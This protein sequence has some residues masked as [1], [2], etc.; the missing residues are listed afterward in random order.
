MSGSDSLISTGYTMLENVAMSGTKE[1]V[2]EITNLI[3]GIDWSN[4]ITAAHKLNQELADG[5]DLTKQYAKNMLTVEREYFGAANQAKYFFESSDYSEMKEGLGEILDAN[6]KIAASDISGLTDQ[7]G[8]LNKFMK[9]TGLSAAAV[10]KLL[11]S[12]GKKKININHLTDAVLASMTEFAS[13][14]TM[15]EDLLDTL[16]NFD[17]G[18]DENEVAGFMKQ[19]YD[20]LSENLSKGAV[21]NT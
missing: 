21:G 2:M 17:A 5:T 7:Y 6:N 15:I 3:N 11:T 1:D 10:A 18:P 8:L 9:N 4:P 20:V 14:E 13:F 12:I 16:S 19:A